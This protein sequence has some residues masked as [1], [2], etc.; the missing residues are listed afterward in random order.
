MRKLMM[1][2]AMLAMVL[3]AAVPA[4]ASDSF[5]L[6]FEGNT[7]QNQEAENNSVQ[8]IDDVSAGDDVI[9]GNQTAVAVGTGSGDVGAAAGN[10]Q[11]DNITIEQFQDSNQ[12][13]QQAQADD[14]SLAFNSNDLFFGYYWYW[15]Y[16]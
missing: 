12:V 10:D 11:S 4:L 9:S 1:L 5:D 13:I 15:Y 16:F 2:A 6:D 14:E 8:V 3:V 7:F